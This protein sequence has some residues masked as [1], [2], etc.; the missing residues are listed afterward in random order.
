MQIVRFYQRRSFHVC[1]L[2]NLIGPNRQGP[3][4]RNLLK[5]AKIGEKCHLVPVGYDWGG[6]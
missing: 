2:K 6:D 3:K 1:S 5:L 4:E